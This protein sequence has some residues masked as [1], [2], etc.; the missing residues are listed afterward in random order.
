MIHDSRLGAMKPEMMDNFGEELAEGV[1]IALKL[2]ALRGPNTRK[3]KIVARGVMKWM[4]ADD[5]DAKERRQS[6]G[7]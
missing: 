4:V 2:Y 1:F 7:A 5:E 6:E 3:E